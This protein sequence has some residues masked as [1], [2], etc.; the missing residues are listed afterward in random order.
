MGGR[1]E[2]FIDDVLPPIV[3]RQVRK[4]RRRIGV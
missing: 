3:N 4:I 1:V 2:R